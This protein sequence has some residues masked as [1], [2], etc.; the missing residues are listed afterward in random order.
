[1]LVLKTSKTFK[2]IIIDIYIGYID[3]HHVFILNGVVGYK[4]GFKNFCVV[5]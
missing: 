4:I 5:L 3:Q 1:M 2:D